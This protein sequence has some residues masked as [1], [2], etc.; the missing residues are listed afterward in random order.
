M[1]F[2]SKSQEIP[3]MPKPILIFQSMFLSL[4]TIKRSHRHYSLN[5]FPMIVLN[6]WPSF[7]WSY[8]AKKI[9]LDINFKTKYDS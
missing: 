8:D 5:S 4:I 7:Y 9:K 6:V 1:D 2:V 3:Y